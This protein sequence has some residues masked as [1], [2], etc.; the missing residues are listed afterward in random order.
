MPPPK[1]SPL[2][3]LPSGLLLLL[4][5]IVL[6]APQ[7]SLHGDNALKNL[8]WQKEN[9]GWI[10]LRNC[11]LDNSHYQDGDSFTVIY[12]GKRLSVRLYFVDAPEGSGDRRNPERGAEQA[13][14]F[15]ISPVENET[16]GNIAQKF[17]GKLLEKPFQLHTQ[18]TNALGTG[19]FPRVYAFVRTVEGDLGELLLRNG[20]GRVKGYQKKP[21]HWQGTET[22]YQKYLEGLVQKAQQQK[23]GIWRQK[24][25]SKKQNN[26]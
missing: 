23:K 5:L 25:Q 6:L 14:D 26:H 12:Q 22:E 9:T 7:N 20:L 17:T 1:S 13:R 18:G 3:H 24:T 2:N 15:G 19:K 10:L 16:L 11:T 21:P 4:T 8:P